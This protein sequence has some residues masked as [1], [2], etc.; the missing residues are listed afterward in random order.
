[1]DDDFSSD[2]FPMEITIDEFSALGKKP[3]KKG[4]PAKKNTPKKGINASRFVQEILDEE[5][6][7]VNLL[8]FTPTCKY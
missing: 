1:M 8:Y 3:K 4:L 5:D 7:E 2:S 6:E